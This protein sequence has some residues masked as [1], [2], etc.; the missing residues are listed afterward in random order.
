MTRL[1]ITIARPFNYTGVGQ[2]SKF[3]NTKNGKPYRDRR[4]TIELGNL[5]IIRE[6]N[7]MSSI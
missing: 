3:F 5:D 2:S 7:D 6:F 1:N 4:E